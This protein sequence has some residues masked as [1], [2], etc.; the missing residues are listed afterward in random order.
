MCNPFENLER[1]GTKCCNL[2][3]F[4]LLYILNPGHRYAEVKKKSLSPP[5]DFK[6]IDSGNVDVDLKYYEEEVKR[7]NVVDEKNKILLTIA[8]LLIAA[9][10]A[11]ATGIEPKGLILFPLIP[12]VASIFLILVH[13]KG[14]MVEWEHL[15]G[16]LMM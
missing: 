4:I 10:S 3:T 15:E 5:D 11:I 14:Q 1:F 2:T 6:E 7:T 12:T 13:F 16:V 9:C 8:A